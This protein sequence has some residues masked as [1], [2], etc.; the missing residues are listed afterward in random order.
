MRR[1]SRLPRGAAENLLCR[2]TMVRGLFVG[3]VLCVLCACLLVFV[4]DRWSAS[5]YQYQPLCF[6]VVDTHFTPFPYEQKKVKLTSPF[7]CAFLSFSFLFSHNKHPTKPERASF[8]MTLIRDLDDTISA[9]ERHQV[10]VFYE[11]VG[12]MVAAERD[13][14][15]KKEL[16]AVRSCNTYSQH[17]S[18]LV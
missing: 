15:R 1:S 11:A 8:M 5:Q 4:G 13:P 18:S 14:A 17:Q 7:V 6:L 3:I 9:L 16:L 12:C 10:L 2:T